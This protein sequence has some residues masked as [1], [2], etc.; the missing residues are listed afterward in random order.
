MCKHNWVETD[1]EDDS[2][3]TVIECVDCGVLYEDIHGAVLGCVVCGLLAPLT[4][5]GAFGWRCDEHN[6]FMKET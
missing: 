3:K 5:C 6:P 2:G 1:L 4:N